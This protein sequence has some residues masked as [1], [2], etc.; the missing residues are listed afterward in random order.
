MS[1]LALKRRPDGTF[2]LDYDSETRDLVLTESL[3]VSVIISIGSDAR[4]KVI[5]TLSLTPLN[6][7]WWGDAVGDDF[8]LGGYVYRA[9]QGKLAPATLVDLKQYVKDALK[10]MVDDGV[11]SDVDV[12]VSIDEQVAVVLVTIAKPS[13]EPENYRFELPWKETLE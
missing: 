5:G 4:E 7:G 12:D 2:D 11:A 3:E 9:L 13:A 6:D 10:W 8:Q 1:D